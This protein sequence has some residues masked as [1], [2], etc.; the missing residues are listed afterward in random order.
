MRESK[1]FRVSSTPSKKKWNA[2]TPPLPKHTFSKENNTLWKTKNIIF[3]KKWVSKRFCLKFSQNMINGILKLIWRVAFLSILN[4]SLRS[5]LS[6]NFRCRCRKYWRW[7]KMW[8]PRQYIQM[9]MLS[10]KWLR[11]MSII[12]WIQSMIEGLLET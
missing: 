4:R 12:N 3:W 7:L 10:R 8:Y 9:G 2:P 11:L 5:I 1:I 6:Q